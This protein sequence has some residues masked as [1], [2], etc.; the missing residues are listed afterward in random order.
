VIYSVFED[1]LSVAAFM[2]QEWS[3]AGLLYSG[4]TPVQDLVFYNYAYPTDLSHRVSYTIQPMGGA[5]VW[6]ILS[7]NKRR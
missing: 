5:H 2:K 6:L 3:K 7:D 4:I 1:E